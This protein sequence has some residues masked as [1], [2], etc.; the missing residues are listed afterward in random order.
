VLARRGDLE[1]GIVEIQRGL[2]RCD[3]TGYVA[4]RS[5]LLGGLAEAQ[6]L[7]GQVEAGLE[8][9]GRALELSETSLDRFHLC[10]LLRLEGELLLLRKDTEG[11]EL[12]FRRALERARERNA[13][14]YELNAAR[15]YAR[16]LEARG[17]SET[18][19]ALLRPVLDWFRAG[20]E[21]PGLGDAKALQ[22]DPA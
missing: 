16:L 3:E 12:R 8:T 6:L 13:R 2:Q 17:E 14:S 18:A 10:E 5:Y 20:F 9:I 7:A 11:A 4:S 21:A 19:R 15:S 22:E 1:G